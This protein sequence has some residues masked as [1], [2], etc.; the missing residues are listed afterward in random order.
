MTNYQNFVKS[1]FR[2]FEQSMFLFSYVPL[3]ATYVIRQKG[4]KKVLKREPHLL[5][6]P[7]NLFL[8]TT[9]LEQWKR[10]FKG[11]KGVFSLLPPHKKDKL[12]GKHFRFVEMWFFSTW[13]ISSLSLKKAID[14][15]KN[16]SFSR[17]RKKERK[18]RE[19]KICFRAISPPQN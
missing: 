11:P 5:V 19:T 14:E 3:A 16:I 18:K 10:F 4:T 15:E 6:S 1:L 7:R 13:K 17:E 12:S 9:K 2:P 8:G